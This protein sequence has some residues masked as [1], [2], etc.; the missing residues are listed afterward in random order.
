MDIGYSLSVD[1]SQREWTR[2][3]DKVII[4]TISWTQFI[5]S[6]VNY[7]LEAGCTRSK[8]THYSVDKK[9]SFVQ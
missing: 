3:L 1:K 7:A 5:N 4:K 6:I 2:L 9:F 8:I